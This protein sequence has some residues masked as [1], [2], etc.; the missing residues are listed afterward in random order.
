[1]H[2]TFTRPMLFIMPAFCLSHGDHDRTTW[3]STRC[4]RVHLHTPLV[5]RVPAPFDG[6]VGEDPNQQ[7]QVSQ[8]QQSNVTC[9]Q[10]QEVALYHVQLSEESSSRQHNAST[11]VAY[12]ANHLV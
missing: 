5:H 9:P 1:M 10:D 3:A 2:C 6:G 8:P 12:S 11:M 4:A 7:A